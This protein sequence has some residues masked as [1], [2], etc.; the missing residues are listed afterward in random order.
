MQII[1]RDGRK[2]EFDASKISDAIFAAASS[3]GGNDRQLA[4]ELAEEIFQ[5]FSETPDVDPTVEQIQDAVQRTLIKHDHAKTATA[6]IL[7]RDNRSRAR[8]T[9]TTLNRTVHALLTV[10]SENMDDKREN[11][12]ID[13]DSVMGTMLKIGGA[14]TKEYALNSWIRPEFAKMHRDG[15]CHQH[16]LDFASSTI[17][18]IQIPADK[19]LKNGFNTGHGS[20]RP[21][22]TIG[23]AAT[24][25]CIILQSSQNDFFQHH[26][27]FM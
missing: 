20:V 17:N 24:L 11:A 7:Y 8:Q 4:D 18:C 3:V 6:F 9:K 19:L 23:A 12:N 26:G 15:A 10:D 27:S 14:A 25:I 5:K 2:M 21:P 13:G 16:D 1:K 22:K